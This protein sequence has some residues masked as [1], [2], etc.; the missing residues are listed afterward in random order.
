MSVEL[1]PTIFDRLYQGFNAPISDLD[2]GKKCAPY[3]E[4]GNPFCCDTHHAVPTAYQSEWIFLQLKTNLWHLWN[5]ETQEV[6]TQLREQTPQGMELIEC[7]GHKQCQRDYRS[8]TCR[9]FPFFPYIDSQMAFIGL[10]YYREY[11]QRCWV[12]SNLDCVTDEYRKQFISTYD[13]IFHLVPDETH[14]FAYQSQQMRMI[15][16]GDARK[17]PLLH[18]NDRYYLVD[19]QDEQMQ[20]CQPDDFPMH[21]PFEIAAQMKFPDEL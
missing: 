13:Q 14:N 9:A 6:D 19:P 11:E 5:G 3:N 7:L 2:C 20:V 17:I 15:F 12:I 21:D 8:I 1:R 10:T 4:K 16:S 18:R